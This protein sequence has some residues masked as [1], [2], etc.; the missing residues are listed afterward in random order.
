M[1]K[2]VIVR[3]GIVENV[4]E[5]DGGPAWSPP[6]GTSAHAFEGAVGIGWPWNDG[7][8]TDPSPP[9]EVEPPPSLTPEQK[10][11]AIGLSSADLRELLGLD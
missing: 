11:A 10:L 4:V 9:A 1:A 2:H 5:W 3:D 7:A 6:D 8:P